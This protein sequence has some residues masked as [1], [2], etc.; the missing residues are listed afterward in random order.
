MNSATWWEQYHQEHWQQNDGS[1][2]TRLFMQGLVA[3]LPATIAAELRAGGRTVLD[4][5]CALGEGVDELARAF[6]DCAVAGAD[7]ADSAIA[8][9]RAHFPDREFVLTDDE[10][11]PAIYDVVV[12]SNCLEH[13][14]NPLA[15]VLRHLQR[16]RRLYIAMVPWNEAPLIDQ[17]F[18]QFREESFPAEL[19]GFRRVHSAVFPVDPRAWPDDQLLV[20]YASPEWQAEH[21]LGPGADDGRGRG[22]GG[23]LVEIQAAVQALRDDP[24]ARIVAAEVR[25]LRRSAERLRADLDVAL[26]RTA[27]GEAQLAASRSEVQRL[28]RELAAAEQRR[29]ELTERLARQAEVLAEAEGRRAAAAA[30][31]ARVEDQLRHLTGSA[32][33][34]LTRAAC[35]AVDLVAPAGTLQHG[36]LRWIGRAVAFVLRLPLRA[37]AWLARRLA[38]PPPMTWYAWFFDR[39]RRRR[40]AN[41]GISGDGVEVPCQ[42]GLVSIVLPVYNGADYIRESLDSILAQDFADFEL[43]VVDD[44]STDATPEILQDYAGRDPRVRVHRQQNQKLPRALN[45]GF[46]RAR[47]EFLT[48]T[49][50][51]NRLKPAFLSRMVAC[52]R[53]HPDWD[54]TWANVDIIGDDGRPLRGSAWYL[55]YQTPPGSEHVA[56][57]EDPSELN[58]WPN[59]YVG[60]AFLYRARVPAL[61]GGYSPF[62]F[63]LEDYDYW[64]RVNAL[65][66]LRHADF[67]EPVYDYRFHQTSLTS[68]DRE[69]GITRSRQ[70]LMVFEEFRRDF[71]QGP[72]VWVLAEATGAAAAVRS[73][74]RARAE[75][76]GHRVLERAAVDA[77]HWPELWTP[78]VYLQCV[79]DAAA[80]P[81]PPE[82]LPGSVARVLVCAGAAAVADDWDLSVQL[83]GPVAPAADAAVLRAADPRALLLAVDVWARSA[84]LER[85][86][87]AVE[88]PEPDR[89]DASVILCTYRRSDRL[90]RAL[91]SVLAQDFDPARFEVIVVDNGQEHA[92]IAEVLQQCRAAAGEEAGPAVRLL[93]A[94]VTGLSHA[95]NAG[96]AAA[97]GRCLLFLDDDAV[98]DPDWVA[99]MVAAFDAHPDAGVIGGRIVLHDPAPA[100][101]WWRPEWRGYWSHFDP[102]HAGY[103]QAAGWWEF[104]WGANW[105]A[106]RTALLQSGGF[107][108]AYG[109]VGNDF[110]GGE[111]LVAGQI[112]VSL[113]WTV[114]VEPRSRVLH[115]VEPARF[116]WQHVQRTIRAAMHVDYQMQ[117]DLYLPMEPSLL[118]PFLRVLR[119]ALPGLLSPRSDRWQRRHAWARIAGAFGVL[120][121]KRGDRRR[122]RGRPLALGG[123][124]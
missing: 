95:R 74:L 78:A 100:P 101:P 33:W 77:A 107:R 80:V 94:P 48:W 47:G 35:R 97:R 50:A 1:T 66:T 112:A 114:G 64:M 5:G 103:H 39:F 34:R 13:F 40:A 68:R 62:R 11:L 120:W 6:P 18:A 21:G 102:G 84:Q 55:H 7:C 82:D 15:V 59:N 44:G 116:T 52:L 63:G 14:R 118:A 17:H 51:D 72:L 23:S 93:H 88:R 73:E 89:F 37:G 67:P 2:Q 60:A 12:T 87:R 83:G 3:A 115:D 90:A 46:R 70:R 108:T 121:R 119:G 9:A 106:R 19:A 99:V 61:L 81:A 36:L 113:G 32:A 71:A 29:A 76:A 109:R 53:R 75:A 30:A 26:A 117:R 8:T 65:L 85:I 25:Q 58:V 4:W 27:H 49:S 31:Q 28:Q 57:P 104:P 43:I 92:A 122:R 45:A 86:E 96:L 110:G 91:A 54:M 20:V 69:L 10:D 111:E 16:T 79:A 98:A 56:L 105:G 123:G 124:R 24:A 42:P 41:V 38:G 22:R